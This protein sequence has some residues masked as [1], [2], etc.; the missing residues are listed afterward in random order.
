MDG[1][2][3]YLNNN[4]LLLGKITANLN[5]EPITGNLT[6]ETSCMDT[7][8]ALFQE[9][10]T[11]SF[12]VPG[13]VPEVYATAT[14]VSITERQG[15]VTD[16]LQDACRL[17]EQRYLLELENLSADLDFSANVEEQQQRLI[18]QGNES[19]A[20]A[21]YTLGEAL[22]Y[23]Q[24]QVINLNPN[25][26]LFKINE[27]ILTGINGTPF[28]TTS[29]SVHTD[30][31]GGGDLVA[32][33]AGGR[34]LTQV[35]GGIRFPAEEMRGTGVSSLIDSNQWIGM[36]LGVAGDGVAIKEPTYNYL[37]G[38]TLYFSV[39]AAAGEDCT[40]DVYVFGYTIA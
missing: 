9:G 25:G 6:I 22:S 30:I 35:D 13:D 17:G 16:A 2:L 20:S 4:P 1:N 19:G 15:Q 28:E 14:I 18:V 39:D 23:G 36:N 7:Q 32:D 8:G 29:C 26:R 27:I 24:S 10:E 5:L 31:D 34:G 11:V 37:V 40:V 38:N 21:G 33:L 12:I 3:I